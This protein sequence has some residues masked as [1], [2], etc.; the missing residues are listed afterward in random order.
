MLWEDNGFPIRF[1]SHYKNEKVDFEIAKRV[2][3]TFWKR[4]MGQNLPYK[5]REGSGNRRNSVR[6][7][8]LTINTDSGWSNIVHDIGHT[9]DFRKYPDLRPHSSQHATLEYR[10]TKL[11][12]DGGYIEKSRQA[13]A[14][15]PKKQT[16]NPVH[17]NYNQ[18]KSR[19]DNLLRKQ[20]QY[21]SNLKRVA[22]SLKKVQK[23]IAQY[24]KKYDQEKLNNKYKYSEPVEKKKVQSYKQKCEQLINEHDW[25]KIERDE[26]WIGEFK[27]DVW[28]KD[29]LEANQDYFDDGSSG[30]HCTWTWKQA[31]NQALVLIERRS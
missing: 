10:F 31:Y 16:L 4:E 2:V 23:S 3:R 24:E 14:D 17:K 1:S 21:E 27:L 30:E 12:F 15:K 22:N 11:I 8:I 26:G 25:L 18:L 28:D 20:K 9:I 6:R 29:Y 19:Q 13:L 7:G 5:I